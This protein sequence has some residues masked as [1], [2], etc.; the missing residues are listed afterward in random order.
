MSGLVGLP[1]GPGW[2]IAFWVILVSL[3]L[4]CLW[5][6]WCVALNFQEWFVG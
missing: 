5:G 4:V 3:C 2:R 1:E 6:L